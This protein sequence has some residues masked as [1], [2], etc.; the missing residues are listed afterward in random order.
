MVEQ[1]M[2]AQLQPAKFELVRWILNPDFVAQAATD[3][4]T[5]S[6]SQSS[7]SSNSSSSSSSGGTSG[8]S[9]ASGGGP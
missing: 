2:D 6:N 1:Q 9:G 3:T 4:E 5:Q 8:G 7:S